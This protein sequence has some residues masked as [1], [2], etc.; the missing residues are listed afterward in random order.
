M[1]AGGLLPWDAQTRTISV[2]ADICPGLFEMFTEVGRT[3]NNILRKNLQLNTCNIFNKKVGWFKTIANLFFWIL[4][5]C[6]VKAMSNNIFRQYYTT[7]SS[8]T[9]HAMVTDNDLNT[10]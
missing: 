9:N 2:S 8:K 6:S 3:V 5:L 7:Q 10:L 4:H 1:S